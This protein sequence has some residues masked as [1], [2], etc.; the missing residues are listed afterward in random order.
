MLMLVLIPM[1]ACSK[2]I[3]SRHSKL[4]DTHVSYFY[5]FNTSRPT[6]D[7]SS[8]TPSMSATAFTKG[9]FQKRCLSLT[10]LLTC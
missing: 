3:G 6:S 1:E 5:D 10:N 4:E 8:G 9:Y 7:L 2:V